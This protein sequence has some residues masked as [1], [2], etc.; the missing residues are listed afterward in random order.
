MR[1]QNSKSSLAVN[2]AVNSIKTIKHFDIFRVLYLKI[3]YKRKEEI[4]M[5]YMTETEAYY[6]YK[7]IKQKV[8][9]RN[10][11]N[12]FD[13]VIE[14]EHKTKTDNIINSIAANTNNIINEVTCCL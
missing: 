2:S 14:S 5:N 9:L 13:K 4:F 10:I 6:N 8:A 3:K 7:G 1:E 12:D 11:I